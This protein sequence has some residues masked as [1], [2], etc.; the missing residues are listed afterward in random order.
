MSAML[1][2]LRIQIVGFILL[3]VLAGYGLREA[4]GHLREERLGVGA[5]MIVVSLACAV[6]AFF[7]LPTVMGVLRQVGSGVW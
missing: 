4:V 7:L 5:G 1:G 6:G 3:V 2:L